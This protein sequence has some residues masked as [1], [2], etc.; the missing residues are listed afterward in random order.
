METVR[1]THADVDRRY[2]LFPAPTPGP[3]V[4]FLHG[5]GGTAEWAADEAELPAFAAARGFTLV[6]PEALTP[7]PDRPPAFLS[8]PPRWNDGS[9]APT[10]ELQTDT[11]DSGCLAEVIADVVR[12]GAA[13]PDRITVTG[14]SNGAG[15]AFR[16]AAEYAELVAAVVPVAGYWHTPTVRPAR[17][18][19]TLFMVGD[20]DPLIPL[21]AGPV[22]LPWGNTTIH[23]PSVLDSVAAWAAANGCGPAEVAS[24]SDG[25]RELVYP[26]P[27]EV[28]AVIVG[29]LGHHWPG[30]KGRLNPRIGGRPSD[31]LS[32][33]ERL[34]QF[35]AD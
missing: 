35:A 17:P 4:L 9:A 16:F 3:A 31:R 32:A 28:R 10:P 20:A 29:G 8:N 12:R 34:W 21:T 5:T 13:D 27:V 24:D 26:G 15:M 2:L 30:G 25:L 1:L 11:D 23:R 14:F 7:H 33:N 19:R 18:V 22:R 6:V